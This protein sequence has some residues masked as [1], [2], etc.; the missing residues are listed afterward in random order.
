MYIILILTIIFIVGGCATTMPLTKK[1]KQLNITNE[2]VVIMSLK[3]INQYKAR[4]QPDVKRIEV[5]KI[6]QSEGKSFKIEK[7]YNKVKG[8]HNEYLRLIAY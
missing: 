2:G 5:I 3:T 1:T 7:A 6:D 8:Q 4:Y